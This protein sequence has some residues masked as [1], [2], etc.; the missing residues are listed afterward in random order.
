MAVPPMA[1]DGGAASAAVALFVGA[2]PCGRPGVHV[3]DDSATA[4]AVTEICRGVDGLPLGIELAAAWTVSLTPVDLQHR[5]ERPLPAADRTRGHQRSLRETVAWSYDLLDDEERAVLSTASV[6]AGGF[7]VDVL[8]A[9]TGIEDPIEVLDPRPLPRAQV[10]RRRQPDRGHRPVQPARDHPSVRR[11]RARRRPAGSTTR[12]DR[13]AACFARRGDRRGGTC[14]TVPGSTMRSVGWRP[15]SRTCVPRS[16][17]AWHGTT[18][19]R[20][21]TSLRTRRMIGVSA[22]LFEAVGWVEEIIDAAAAAD[23]RRLPAAVH[24]GGIQLL[25]R[26]ARSRSAHAQL[27]TALGGGRALRRRS[28]PGRRCS[29]RRSPRCT[30]DSWTTTWSSPA[31]VAELPG[32]LPGVRP[33]PGSSMVSR[34]P[35]GS[36]RRSRCAEE[37]AT[38]RAARQRLLARRIRSGCAGSVYSHR[39]PARALVLWGEAP[40][41]G[42]RARR[43]ASSRVHRAG[44]RSACTRRRGARWSALDPLRRRH[45][46]LPP[47]RQRRPARHHPGE[48]DVTVRSD[49]RPGGRGTLYGAMQGSGRSTT[50]CPTSPSSP[51]DLTPALAP[52]RFSRVM[53]VGRPRWSSMTPLPTPFTR[54]SSRGAALAGPSQDGGAAFT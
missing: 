8:G 38:P 5:L 37:G 41:Y 6:F 18:S 39:R 20:R 54:S 52:D 3:F 26:T 28:T 25:H 12:R 21:P 51:T 29:S 30:A 1:L 4:D 2:G 23:I 17:G 19:R 46:L 10:P 31:C 50:T 24:R 53:A 36:T 44:R 16:A 42:Q 33:A 14:G 49:R 35:D 7:D 32:W 48:P 43:H 47:F 34:R 15:S 11:A 40:D 27:A 22:E 45:R 9:V 13:H